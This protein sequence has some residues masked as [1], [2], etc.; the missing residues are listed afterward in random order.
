MK[1]KL[2]AVFSAS[3]AACVAATALAGC[4]G[5][6]AEKVDNTPGVVNIVMLEAGYGTE[7]MDKW[8]ED[9]KAI[10]G[11][12]D[13]KFTV[14]KDVSSTETATNAFMDGDDN[15]WDLCFTG[16]IVY[17]KYVDQGVLEDISDVISEF[18]N[19]LRAELNDIISYKNGQ[20]L[21]PWAY[22]PCGFIYNTDLLPSDKIPVTTDE[23][24]K[25]SQ[26]I[27]DGKIESAKNAKA[28]V[29]AGQNAYAYWDYVTDVWW[30]QYEYLDTDYESGIDAYNNFWSLN[31][32]DPDGYTVYQQPGLEKAYEVLQTLFSNK[33]L[34]MNGSETKSHT[35]SQADF[36][37]GRAVMIPCGGWLQNEMKEHYS[38][39]RNYKMMKTPVISA[40]GKELKLAGASATDIQHEEKL[41][42]VVKAIDA[43]KTAEVIASELNVDAEKVETVMA[44]RNL[45]TSIGI[46]HQAWIPATSNAMENAKKFL[47]YI[48]S[49]S[50]AQ[51]FRQYANSTLPF[52]YDDL[53]LQAETPFLQ[54]MNEIHSDC[55]FLFPKMLASPIRYKVGLKKFTNSEDVV[56]KIWTG[57]LTAKTFVEGEYDYLVGESG[58]WNY[59][60]KQI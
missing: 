40:L 37:L 52:E 34:F 57:E 25:L 8:I 27:A 7:F 54:S 18:E 17:K 44:A 47:A 53:A 29:W 31:D 19:P 9:F 46:N 48:G 16:D 55:K 56:K 38:D 10:P 11:N 1:K 33:K 28:F 43:G 30:T 50:A 59:Y 3:M 26:E 5:L 21:V 14:K 24:L 2:L 4:G 41:V 60:Y 45:S 42:A 39:K 22:D 23:L 32:S 20:W 51:I 12:E 35:D 13:I 49:D 6:R 15:P 58:K 36:V